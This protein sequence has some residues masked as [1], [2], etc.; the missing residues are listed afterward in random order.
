MA[1][2]TSWDSLHRPVRDSTPGLSACLTAF[3]LHCQGVARGPARRGLG[4]GG[5]GA[6]P[7]ATGR[8]R[9]SSLRPN[10][11]PSF[12]LMIMAA[13]DWERLSGPTTLNKSNG[14][15]LSLS[16]SPSWGLRDFDCA[17]KEGSW[18]LRAFQLGPLAPVESY[19]VASGTN[20]RY[21]KSCWIFA[22]LRGRI[23]AIGTRR[24]GHE[25][26]FVILL[27]ARANNIQSFRCS[28]ATEKAAEIYQQN[29]LC[30]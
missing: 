17:T 23:V 29:I 9:V 24:T 1:F 14:W 27:V 22:L 18:I 19:L 3:K 2:G 30:K 4:C 6:V 5:T 20:L 16:D 21:H 25:Y 28:A 7:S 15:S 11:R 13:A 10:E 8:V 26:L 12:R